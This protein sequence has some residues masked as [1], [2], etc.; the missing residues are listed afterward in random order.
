MKLR[1]IIALAMSVF[2][3]L[4]APAKDAGDYSAGDAM[5]NVLSGFIRPGY[6]RLQ[7][8]ADGLS[9]ATGK[10]C[11]SADTQTLQRVEQ[12]FSELVSAWGGIEMIRFGPI[13]ADNHLERF[14]FYPDRRSTSLKRINRLLAEKEEKALDPAKLTKLSVALQGLTA[15]DIVLSGTGA[16]ALLKTPNSHRC[17]YA[18]AIAANLASISTLLNRE[19]HGDHEFLYLWTTPGYRNPALA[20]DDTAIAHLIST[21]V[22]GLEVVRDVRLAAFL[23][24]SADDDRPK[25]APLWRSGNTM[26]L[27]AANLASVEK[28]YHESDLAHFLPE[29]KKLIARSI[30]SEFATLF[31][32]VN[33]D[34]EP[35]Q[36]LSN[37]VERARLVRLRFVISQLITTFDK[38]LAGTLGLSIGFFFD[39]GD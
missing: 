17:R 23:K 35:A 21:I 10:L 16:E 7:A 6:Q 8:A 15:F 29:D 18:M 38:Q 1:L 37:E 33:R 4:P 36:A 34:I 3:T 27:L 12:R 14:F 2:A 11:Q 30:E 31:E 22:H 28:I 19:W 9:S 25:S 39:D 20:S 13:L 24:E 32:L 5:E 26:G